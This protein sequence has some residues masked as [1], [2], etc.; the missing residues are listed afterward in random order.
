MC[1]L[2]ITIFIKLKY[3]GFKL[4]LSWE[5]QNQKLFSKESRMIKRSKKED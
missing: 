4:D 2:L 5:K 3:F 1:T